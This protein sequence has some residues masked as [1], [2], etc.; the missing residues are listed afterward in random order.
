LQWPTAAELLGKPPFLLA[1]AH[2]VDAAP[3]PLHEQPNRSGSQ[4]DRCYGGIVLG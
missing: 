2:D 4:I 3:E 1:D